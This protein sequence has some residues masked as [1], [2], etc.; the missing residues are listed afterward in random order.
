MLQQDVDAALEWFNASQSAT[1]EVTGIVDAELSLQSSDPHH[2]IASGCRERGWLDLVV[3]PKARFLR[4]SAC[5]P[6]RGWA[7]RC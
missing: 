5:C 2:E 1:F 6:R 7:L 4:H 3:N